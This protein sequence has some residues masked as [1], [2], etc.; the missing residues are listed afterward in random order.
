MPR[1][2]EPVPWASKPLTRR[3][4]LRTFLITIGLLILVAGVTLVLGGVIAATIAHF[5]RQGQ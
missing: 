4:K 1:R 3:E 2:P 5:V